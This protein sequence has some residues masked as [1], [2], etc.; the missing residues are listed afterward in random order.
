V[1]APAPDVQQGRECGDNTLYDGR[2]GPVFPAQPSSATSDVFFKALVYR[3]GHARQLTVLPRGHCE[4]VDKRCFESSTVESDFPLCKVK[5]YVETWIRI[6][7]PKMRNF[8]GN[9]IQISF[10]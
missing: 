2:G 6:N 7:T 8:G 3:P 1:L 10:S 9:Y 4:Y 5:K